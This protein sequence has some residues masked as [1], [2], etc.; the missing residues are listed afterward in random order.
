MRSPL[1]LALLLAPCAGLV[2]AEDGV[3]PYRPSVSTPAQLPVPGQLEMEVGGL[4]THGG[5]ERRDSVP[6]L[7]KLA[8]SSEWGVL[9]GA[10]SFVS[11]RGADGART[12]GFGD[13]SVVIKR[14]FVVD[15]ATAYGLEL[16]TKVPTAGS[17]IGSGKADWTLN[18]IY[19]QDIGQLHMDVNLNETRLGAP[20][21]G[22]ARMQSGA[23]ASF[24][25]PVNERWTA[26]WEV[27]GARNAGTPSTAQFL[28]ALSYAPTKR[29]TMDAG[30]ARGLTAATPDWSFFTGLV[31]PLA[32]LW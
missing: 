18:A 19:S 16:G 3:S 28:A 21:P 4:S 32:K 7:F 29:L 6:V 13:T 22:A 9:V 17:A 24:G 25:H 26:T 1:F 10:D 2:H 11:L 15:D 20:D 30:F 5:D 27:S 8:F 12:R 31:V 14:A 23:S